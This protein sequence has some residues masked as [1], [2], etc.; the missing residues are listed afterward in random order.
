MQIFYLKPSFDAKT[1]F[2]FDIPAKYK[3]VTTEELIQRFQ[4]LL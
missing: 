1:D 2:R 3:K 4:N